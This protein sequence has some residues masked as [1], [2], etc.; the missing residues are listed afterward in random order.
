MVNGGINE[1][2]GNVLSRAPDNRSVSVSSSFYDCG[3][4]TLDSQGHSVLG[5]PSQLPPLLSPDG[6]F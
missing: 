1:M 3:L 4:L 5:E 6:S 2:I